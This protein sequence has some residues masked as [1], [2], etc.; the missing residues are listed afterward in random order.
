M[1][2]KDDEIPAL[3]PNNTQNNDL[4]TLVHLV[5][6]LHVIRDICII[7]FFCL[8][9][10]DDIRLTTSNS[11]LSLPSEGQVEV[12]YN[13]MWGSPCADG[14]DLNDARVVCRQLGFP[15]AVEATNSTL[16]GNGSLVQLTNV[17]CNGSEEHLRV[18]CPFSEMK[19][20]QNCSHGE[21]GVVCQGTLMGADTLDNANMSRY[22]TRLINKHVCQGT[23]ILIYCKH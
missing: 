22:E 15:D 12:F 21:A 1:Q 20:G 3:P 23:Q 2:L 6:V 13:G 9:N 7:I 19:A 11:S 4:Y 16:M 10:T 18:E 17:Q 8:I 14:W 5:K